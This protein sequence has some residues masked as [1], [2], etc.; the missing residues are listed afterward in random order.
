LENRLKSTSE[1]KFQHQFVVNCFGR[2]NTFEC[3]KGNWKRKFEI[4]L[5][6]G[7]E[8][9][10]IKQIQIFCSTFFRPEKNFL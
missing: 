2:K 8:T 7:M 1:W 3:E 9:E 10:L 6:E 5:I 4:N